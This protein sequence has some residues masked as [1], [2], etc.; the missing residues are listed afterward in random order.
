MSI[1]GVFKRVRMWF[2]DRRDARRW[3]KGKLTDKEIAALRKWI[4]SDDDV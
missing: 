1:L 2:L 3:A 4:A